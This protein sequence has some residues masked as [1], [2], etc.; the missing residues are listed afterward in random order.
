MLKSTS[1]KYTCAMIVGIVAALLIVGPALAHTRIVKGDFAFV[2]GWLDEP[3]VVNVKNAAL[4]AIT[5]ASDN[6]PI[7]GAE[8]TL[9]AQIQYGGKA[10]DLILRPLAGSPGTYVGD[11]IPTRR[12]TYTL[13]IGGTLNN[14]P[15]DL[16]GD[17]EEVGSTD[18]LA[19]PE[20]VNSDLQKSIDDLRSAVTTSQIVGITGLAVGLI[21]L[22]LIVVLFRRKRT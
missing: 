12:G 15:I 3:P 1:L 20:P 18:S 21:G 2:L 14:Q 10:R 4:I 22:M 17:I 9:T 5:T 11:F 16:A 8:G 7:N 6:Q 13:K 19:F